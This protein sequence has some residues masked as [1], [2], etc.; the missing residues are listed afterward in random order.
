METLVEKVIG[1]PGKQLKIGTMI[2]QM[3]K[4]SD[5]GKWYPRKVAG[6][7]VTKAGTSTT[8]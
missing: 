6:A 1:H 7:V 8:E 2:L 5:S 4:S 3:R